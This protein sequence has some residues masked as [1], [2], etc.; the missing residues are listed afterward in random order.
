MPLIRELGI[1]CYDPTK[2]SEEPLDVDN[3]ACD[4]AR[5]A[6]V[7]HDRGRGLARAYPI[8]TDEE[9]EAKLQAEEAERRRVS[10]A[11]KAHTAEERQRDPFDPI[12]WGGADE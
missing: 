3:H 4:A 8:E 12:W 7:G 10:W 2:L 5:Y 11:A 9:V 1:Y 6:V